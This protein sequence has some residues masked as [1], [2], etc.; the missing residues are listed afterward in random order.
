MTVAAGGRVG[1]IA[2][3][4]AFPVAVAREAVAAGREVHILGI[5]GEAEPAI[6]GF[7]HSWIKWGEIGHLLGELK[8]TGCGE[9]VIIGGVTRPDLDQVR[10]DLGAI[11]NLPLVLSLMIGGD[12]SVLSSVVRFFEA[13]G[14]VVR[15]AHEIAPSLVVGLGPLGREHPSAGD[16]KDIRQ[17]LAVVRALGS[18]DVGQ[19]AVVTRGHVIAVE[20]AEGTD[21]MLIRAADLRQW[22]RRRGKRMGVLVKRPKPRQE[23]RVDMPAM[24]PRTVELAA[25]AG[26]AG[27]AVMAHGVLIA[28]RAEIVRIADAERIFIA[29]V[30]DTV[31]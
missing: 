24:G 11:R 26:L 21:Q 13:K 15:G 23:L 28:E 12:D 8:R 17:G 14:L 1:I 9:L 25:R 29:G 5:V 31:A 22:G 4:G 16:E 19:A 18:L 3:G 2:G 30:E 10:L 6:E 20:A 27:V 7:S